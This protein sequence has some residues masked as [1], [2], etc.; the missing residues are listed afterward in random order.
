MK[1]L[2]E[3]VHEEFWGGGISLSPPELYDES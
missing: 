1:A 2:D 3:R